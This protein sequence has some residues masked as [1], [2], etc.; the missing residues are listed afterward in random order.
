MF[1]KKNYK[2]ILVG[3]A[4]FALGLFVGLS[5]K[6]YLGDKGEQPFLQEVW[7]RAEE[8]YPFEEPSSRDKV[9]A[10]ASGLINA[11]ADPHSAFFGPDETKYLRETI[12]GEFAGVGIEI[13]ALEEGYLRVITPL[14]ESPAK[15]AGIKSGDIIVSIDGV[16]LLGKSLLE[17]IAAIRGEVG[18][19]VEFHVLREGQEEPFLV[20]VERDIIKIPLIKTEGI[21]DTFVVSLYNFNEGSHLEFKKALEDFVKSG[22]KNLMLDLRNNPGGYLKDCID[23]ASY[24]L[25]Q[26]L[27]VLHEDT[28]KEE[29]L[30]YRSKGFKLVPQTVPVAILINEGSASA[31]EILAG[32]I[33]DHDRGLVIG[34][35][36]YGKGSVQELVEMPEE[37]ALKMTIARWLTPD[38]HHISRKGIRPDITLNE[39]GKGLSLK[40]IVQIFEKK[41]Q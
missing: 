40:E 30:S 11:Y 31:S 12:A 2:N 13:D 22:K 41:L 34:R 15:K 6:S 14:M 1:L 27:V 5:F 8:L 20:S 28:G 7:K 29:Y 32:A 35:Q 39:E 19:R 26:G 25:D 38:K 10:A 36:S 37:T 4:L 9:Y 21:G 33:Q 16:S 24:F 18:S 23:I 3:L 17:S